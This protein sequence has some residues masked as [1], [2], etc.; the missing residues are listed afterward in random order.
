MGFLIDQTRNILKDSLKHNSQ[1]LNCKPS[2]VQIFIGLT[3]KGDA[4]LPEYVVMRDYDFENRKSV[5]YKELT[6]TKV[7]IMGK[8]ELCNQY[9]PKFLQRVASEKKINEKTTRVMVVGDDSLKNIGIILY[10]NWKDVK[11]ITLD[12]FFGEDE[13]K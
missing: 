3:Q 13:D 9:L 12:Y 2:E 11:N 6:G 5:S 10:D 8:E 7:D 4:F 1:L